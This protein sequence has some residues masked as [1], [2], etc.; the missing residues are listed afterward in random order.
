MAKKRLTNPTKG[1]IIVGVNNCLGVCAKMH[2][3]P[4]IFIF[5]RKGMK[6]KKVLSGFLAAAIAVT[7]AV[8]TPLSVNAAPA[9]DDVTIEV[10]ISDDITAAIFTNEAGTYTVNG[11]EFIFSGYWGQLNKQEGTPAADTE[12]AGAFTTSSEEGSSS[13]LTFSVPSSVDSVAMKTIGWSNTLSKNVAHEVTL[14]VS[15]AVDNMLKVQLVPDG[16]VATEQTNSWYYLQNAKVNY[17]NAEAAPF[18]GEEFKIPANGEWNYQGTKDLDLGAFT[19]GTLQDFIDCVQSIKTTFKANGAV[20]GTNKNYDITNITYQFSIDNTNYKWTVVGSSTTS[21]DG[22]VTI[23][24]DNAAI[25][26]AIEAMASKESQD[27]TTLG[28]T[29]IKLVAMVDLSKADSAITLYHGDITTT[30]EETKA[31]APT[32]VTV[33]PAT[34]ALKVGD[35]ASALTATVAPEGAAQDV[36]WASANESIATVSTDGKVTAV[37]PGT[38]KITATAKDTD[39]AVVGECTVT[40]TKPATGVK[41]ATPAKTTLVVNEE[42]QLEAAAVP[43]DATDATTI[44]WSSSD[45][46]I[47]TVDA[48]GKVTA[49]KAGDVEITATMGTFTDKVA[50]K[51]TD[52]VTPATGIVLA[53]ENLKNGD[54]A[55]FV[56]DVENMTATLTPADS[57]DAVTWTSSDPAI[58]EVVNGKITAVSEGRTTISATANENVSAHILV[59][60][61][62]KVIAIT[63]VTLDKTTASVEEGKT[64]TLTATVAPADTTEDKTVTWKSSDETVATVKDGV[65]TAVKAGTANI[66][67]TAGGKT[68]TCAVTVTAKAEDPKPSGNALWEGTQDMTWSDSIQIAK[69][70]FAD[71]KAGDTIEITVTK[72][73]SGAQ[74]SLKSMGEGWP[75]LPA[76]KKIDPEWGCDN[77]SKADTYKY[78]MTEDDVKAL[79]ADGMAVSGNGYTVT[80]VKLVAAAEEPA[81]KTE[82]ETGKAETV[83]DYVP[84]ET[85]AAGTKTELKVN[86]ISVDDAAKYSSYDITITVTLK[87]G[88]KKTATKS[89]SD[90]YKGFTYSNGTD[91]TTV[92]AAEGFFIL[93][94]VKNV[95]ADATVEMSIKGVE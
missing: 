43:E 57:T 36:V 79:K 5:R 49:K 81:D 28:F 15:K 61:T 94:K 54:L 89:V 90:C 84:K 45:T 80:S 1:F 83:K 88:T 86:S 93:V 70:K 51:V 52:T 14:D 22:T 25:K 73:A 87:D 35:P 42:F 64:V 27:I 56:G 20:S 24:A 13:K 31:I 74:I 72:A 50:L 91:N 9:V 77:I 21:A 66:T 67:A 6:L 53:S 69:E 26:T 17:L 33:T 59:T 11:K 62:K 39:P 78:V 47:A 65:V 3:A 12:Y 38:V 82:Y 85:P 10:H 95:P 7:T 4:E 71:L 16:D 29:G 55:L 30:I 46:A 40:V 8:I 48:D 32:S 19:A 2:T 34:L 44:T 68:A 37:A 63:G 58:A 41:I 23:T 75:A 60:V 18:E 76:F 92:K